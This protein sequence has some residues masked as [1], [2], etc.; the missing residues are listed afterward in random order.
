MKRTFRNLTDTQNFRH[1][2]KTYQRVEIVLFDEHRTHF[3]S[4]SVEWKNEKGGKVRD[5][6]AAEL[7]EVYLNQ[8]TF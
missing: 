6:K 2:G 7:E 5:A 8:T 1:N 3:N 4:Q